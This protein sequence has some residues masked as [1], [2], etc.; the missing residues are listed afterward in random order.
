MLTRAGFLL[1]RKPALSPDV[2]QLTLSPR[3]CFPPI[4]LWEHWPITSCQSILAVS[5]KP[6]ATLLSLLP[7][8]RHRNQPLDTTSLSMETFLSAQWPPS[9]SVW[10]GGMRATQ[11]SAV[12]RPSP[13]S[14]LLLCLS[15][16]CGD[17]RKLWNSPS[18]ASGMLTSAPW[19]HTSISDASCLGASS[20]SQ[21]LDTPTLGCWA[22]FIVA[23]GR[24]ASQY[25]AD[26]E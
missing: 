15:S 8:V 20:L 3:R 5:P 26:I 9:L 10:A 25:G 19:S 23:D 16:T 18:C 1:S 12:I 14:Y 21:H 6:S 13:H 11:C 4:P 17:R 2:S 7:D 22:S 24:Q